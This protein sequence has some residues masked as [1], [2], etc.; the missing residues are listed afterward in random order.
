MHRHHVGMIEPGQGA[1]LGEQA[2]VSAGIVEAA[3]V[4]QLEGDP[5]IE[6]RIVGA[7]D[8]AHAAAGDRPEQDEASQPRGRG[9]AEQRTLGADQGLIERGPIDGGPRDAQIAGE[10]AGRAVV[11]IRV[12]HAGRRA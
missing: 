12:G 1:G 9:R 10:R 8:H 6:I 2:I 7:V 4:D 3:G 11:V 5:S